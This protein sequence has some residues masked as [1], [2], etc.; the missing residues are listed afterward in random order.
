M[1]LRDTSKFISLVLRHKPDAIGIT[2]DEHGWANVD[3]LIGGIA[4]QQRF[5]IAM[6]EKIVATDEKQRYSFIIPQKRLV[7]GTEN[8]LYIA[9]RRR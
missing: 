1:S 9:S 2:L 6:L 5:D 3:E 7:H 4:K 8:L